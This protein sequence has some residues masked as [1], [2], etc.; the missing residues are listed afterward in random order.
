[1]EMCT[2]GKT[3]KLGNGVSVEKRWETLES[4][5]PLQSMNSLI[6]VVYDPLSIVAKRHLLHVPYKSSFFNSVFACQKHIH[7]HRQ[8]HFYSFKMSAVCI[9]LA[10]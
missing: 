4:K 10:V 9:T 3:V 1:M 6:H 2:E 7:V 8:V 5:L